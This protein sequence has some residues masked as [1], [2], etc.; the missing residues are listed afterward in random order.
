[1]LC[2]PLLSVA[3]APAAADWPCYDF[4]M[5][6]DDTMSNSQAAE[7]VRA[8]VEDEAESVAVY[9]DAVGF[10]P[11]RLFPR[12][13][14]PDCDPPKN[15]TY[16]I[17]IVKS[18]A[19]LVGPGTIAAYGQDLCNRLDLWKDSGNILI[20]FDAMKGTPPAHIHHSIAH[21]LNHAIQFNSAFLNRPGRCTASLW[22]REA[23][24]NGAGLL[25]AHESG[26]SMINIGPLIERYS[27]SY[28]VAFRPTGSA[29][30]LKALGYDTGAFFYW[31]GLRYGAE[32]LSSLY[33]RAVVEH[34]VENDTKPEI[35]WIDHGMTAAKQV[36]TGLEFLFPQFVADYGSW[37]EDFFKSSNITSQNDWMEWVFA[38]PGRVGP[39][40]ETL[41]LSL[42][43]PF[44]DVTVTL[45]PVSA[46]CIIVEIGSI[47]TAMALET[48]AY[49]KGANQS[50]RLDS[51]H[52]SFVLRD[53]PT[54]GRQTCEE[55]SGDIA[56]RTWPVCVIKPFMYERG[57]T[58][59]LAA[60]NELTRTYKYAKEIIDSSTLASVPAN[61]QGV[62]I[63]GMA[64]YIFDEPNMRIV[65]AL[66]NVA[67]DPEMTNSNSVTFVAGLRT[68]REFTEAGQLGP[69]RLIDLGNVPAGLGGIAT[70][71]M[72]R[73]AA[74]Q[75]I[76]PEATAAA[77]A[78]FKLGYAEY[79]I[80][81]YVPMGDH[82]AVML[83]IPVDDIGGGDFSAGGYNLILQD[84][85]PLGE[86]GTAKAA[87]LY[88]DDSILATHGACGS[89]EDHVEA[90]I[91]QSGIE[92]VRLAV[93]T[94]M[95]AVNVRNP[96]A[97]CTPWTPFDVE[98]S[99]PFGWPFDAAMRP[100]HIVTP[101]LHAYVERYLESHRER[102]IPM[103]ALAPFPGR[104]PEFG[105]P[106]GDDPI[107]DDG[108]AQATA[109][110]VGCDCS[111]PVL[112][113]MMNRM[114]E[115]DD[116][117]D[118]TTPSPEIM[119]FASCMQTCMPQMFACQVEA[120]N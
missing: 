56:S 2:T 78:D 71:M 67:P 100:R 96:A 32:Y 89:N 62:R 9:F 91:L 93:S 118:S 112:N 34:D 66:S 52:L 104:E 79:G 20:A 95:S 44:D 53:A 75:D 65:F 39:Q 30:A 73:A 72:A 58:T 59:P 12:H 83:H 54:S 5:K 21:E 29:A 42:S 84:L 38:V 120:Q 4:T 10:Q 63:W 55:I 88:A 33:Q 57:D 15:T 106:P 43:K 101:G 108:D 61:T 64:D 74:G 94:P 87:V 114:K 109:A 27:R 76:G 68:V 17:W 98:L 25:S 92:G 35:E 46:R 119:E 70:E 14:G 7:S 22:L 40:C 116:G 117:G 115:L 81:G 31:A 8:T 19:K 26:N 97:G 103:A 105:P 82:H 1:V 111:C 86:T 51:T 3:A 6:I 47:P 80:T 49:A 23:L 50:E 85:P 37:R 90:R 11:P 110:E 13:D 36:Q 107:P 60:A 77:I 28:A 69:P 102:G 18:L 48:F 99:V 113:D 41:H 24:A 45:E 16:E